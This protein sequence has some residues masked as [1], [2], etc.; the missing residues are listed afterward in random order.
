[1][2]QR[3][4]RAGFFVQ[5]KGCPFAENRQPELKLCDGLSQPCTALSIAKYQ[6]MA[7]AVAEHT[8]RAK[9]YGNAMTF[10]QG[11]TFKALVMIESIYELPSVAFIH[12]LSHG[13]YA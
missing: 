8:G 1:M 4:E 9:T 5:T 12:E 6:Q 2:A 7:P 11:Y 3:R 13:V 10:V